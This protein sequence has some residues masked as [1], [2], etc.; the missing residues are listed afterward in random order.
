[1]DIVWQDNIFLVKLIL[2]NFG[3]N[4]QNNVRTINTDNICINVVHSEMHTIN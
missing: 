3:C 1:M 4:G 2:Y